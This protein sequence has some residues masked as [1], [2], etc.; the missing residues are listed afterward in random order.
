MASYVRPVVKRDST[1]KKKGRKQVVITN[2]IM[3]E[4]NTKTKSNSMKHSQIY[5]HTFASTEIQISENTHVHTLAHI[6][7]DHY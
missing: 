2:N 6:N 3:Y 1:L 5:V 4:E 7:T